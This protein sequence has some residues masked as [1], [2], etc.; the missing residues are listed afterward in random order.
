MDVYHNNA[1]KMKK[2]NNVTNKSQALDNIITKS[3]TKKKGKN[4]MHIYNSYEIW[5]SPHIYENI[6]AIEL[7]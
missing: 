2:W 3:W 5:T 4:L 6:W 7:V 1:K